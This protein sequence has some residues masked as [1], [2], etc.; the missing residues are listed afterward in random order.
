MSNT[1]VCS[2]S[3]VHRSAL[4]G[5][6]GNLILFLFALV[7]QRVKDRTDEA[8]VDSEAEAKVLIVCIVSIERGRLAQVSQ[9]LKQVC[10]QRFRQADE[11]KQRK[12][13]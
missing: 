8:H 6:Q 7:H 11:G 5:C 12:Q 13:C 10:I 9:V 2:T 4:Y 1:F 3:S